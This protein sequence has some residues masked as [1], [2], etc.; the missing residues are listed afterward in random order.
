MA[1]LKVAKEVDHKSSHHK[2]AMGGD[3]VSLIVAIT[4]WYTHILN[5]NVHLKLIQC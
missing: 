5:H 2:E 1:Y 3:D 4:S